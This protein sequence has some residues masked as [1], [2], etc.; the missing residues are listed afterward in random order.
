MR[1][2]VEVVG[3]FTL[4]VPEARGHRYRSVL[5]GRDGRS[6]AELAEAGAVAVANSADSLSGWI[7]FLAAASTRRRAGRWPGEVIWS[8]AHIE[9]LRHLQRRAAPTWRASTRSA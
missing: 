8:G 6:L 5:V 7:S 3:A 4:T 1:D 9:S 2:T